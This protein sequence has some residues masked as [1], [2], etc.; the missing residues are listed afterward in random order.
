MGTV[1]YRKF[2]ISYSKFVYDN[3]WIRNIKIFVEDSTTDWVVTKITNFPTNESKEDY[4]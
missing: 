4:N 1:L 3:F 2:D